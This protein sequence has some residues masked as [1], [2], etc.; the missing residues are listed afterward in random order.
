MTAMRGAF[1]VTPHQHRQGEDTF[2][3]PKTGRKPIDDPRMVTG[4]L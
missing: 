3:R 2:L 1:T 4:T